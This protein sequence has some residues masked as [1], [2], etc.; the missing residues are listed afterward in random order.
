MS[1]ILDHLAVACT[2]LD[3]GVAWVEDCLGVSML[4]GGQHPRYGTHN[5]LLGL[6][7]GLYFEVIAVDPGV[8]SVSE[9]R[10]FGLDSF[11]GRPRLANW[12]C[13]AK[14]M[15]AQLAKA[16]KSVGRLRDMQRGGLTWQLTVPDDG[17]LP[18]GGAFPT[19]IKWPAG[20]HPSKTLPE[21]G[22]RLAA[23]VV[24]HPEAD[25]LAHMI[26]LDDPRVVFE[27]GPQGFSAM[28]DTPHGPRTLS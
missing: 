5:K 17:S 18:Y 3:E 26:D 10:W 28:F 25:T 15:Q 6:A 23:F 13:A 9:P 8:S 27:T 7:D 16:P 11:A 12:I 19:L 21:S 14:D 22:C 20:V 1:L 2:D 4:P 24:T